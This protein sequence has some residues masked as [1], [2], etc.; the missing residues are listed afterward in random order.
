MAAL[1][2]ALVDEFLHPV[3]LGLGR[4]S[5][6]V[7][8]HYG[9]PYGAVAYE[10]DVVNG[11]AFGEDVVE[12][13]GHGAVADGPTVFFLHE[14]VDVFYLEEAWAVVEIG[15]APVYFVE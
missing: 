2:H 8:S 1:L 5:F 14:G 11:D 12:V 10:G 4:L 3:D 13:L 6:V 9:V 7:F 15:V